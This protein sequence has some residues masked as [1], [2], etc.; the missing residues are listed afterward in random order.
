[1]IG[2]VCATEEEDAVSVRMEYPLLRLG[3][4]KVAVTPAGSPDTLR[5]T[6]PKLNDS[7]RTV[8]VARPD[9]MV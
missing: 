1:M 6:A 9:V 5:F 3:L 8:A 4:L 2:T 7:T